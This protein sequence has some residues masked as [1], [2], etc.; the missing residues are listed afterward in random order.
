[1]DAF[2]LGTSQ[3]DGVDADVARPEFLGENFGR[4]ILPQV[5]V[6]RLLSIAGNGGRCA[7]S[8]IGQYWPACWKLP[9]LQQRCDTGKQRERTTIFRC[10]VFSATLAMRV[11]LEDDP[12]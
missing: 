8:I 12:G 5:K 1:M 10:A 4:P 11:V 6:D 2:N 9:N 7:S 3:R